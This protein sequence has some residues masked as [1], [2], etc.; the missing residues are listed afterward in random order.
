LSKIKG[1]K[2]HSPPSSLKYIVDLGVKGLIE[3]KLLIRE[4]IG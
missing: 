2:V 4:E 3:R 1:P